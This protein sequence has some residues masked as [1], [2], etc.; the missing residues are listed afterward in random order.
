[1]N[2][3]IAAFRIDALAFNFEKLWVGKRNRKKGDK[4]VRYQ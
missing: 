2:K 1:M 3:T 4:N